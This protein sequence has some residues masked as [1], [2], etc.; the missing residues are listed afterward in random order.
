MHLAWRALGTP[1]ASKI[2]Y[3]NTLESAGRKTHRHKA[4]RAPIV[5]FKNTI[6]LAIALNWRAHRKTRRRIEASRVPIYGNR[7]L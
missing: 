7:I 1:T 2:E 3:E 6:N 4:P 5:A